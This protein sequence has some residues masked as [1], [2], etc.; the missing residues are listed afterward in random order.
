MTSVFEPNGLPFVDVADLIIGSLNS[1]AGPWAIPDP[2]NPGMATVVQ[3][4]SLAEPVSKAAPDAEGLS[5]GLHAGAV[6]YRPVLSATGACM[7]AAAVA[8][9]AAVVAR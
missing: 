4:A 6:S 5:P 1:E 9:R 7:G 3:V 8:G 2:V